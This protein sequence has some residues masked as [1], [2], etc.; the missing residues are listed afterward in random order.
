MDIAINARHCR[1]PDSVR[2][3]AT[4]RFTRLRR[5]DRGITAGTLVFDVDAGGSRAEAR[6][7]VAGRPPLVAHGEGP[8]A[9]G[10]MKVA[11][12]RVERQIKRRRQRLLDRRMRPLQTEQ[13]EP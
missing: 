7:A 12:S 13:A 1:I 3:Q 10:A 9:R 4:Q 8:T 5:L 2:N 6:L 11:L